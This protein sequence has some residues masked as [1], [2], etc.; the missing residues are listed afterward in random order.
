MYNILLPLCNKIGSSAEQKE[1]T[2]MEE[3]TQLSAAYVP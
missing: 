1:E 2:E 3:F